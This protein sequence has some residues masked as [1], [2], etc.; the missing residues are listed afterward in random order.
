MC[1]IGAETQNL[2]LWNQIVQCQIPSMIG[3]LSTGVL[4]DFYYLISVVLS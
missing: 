1:E 3:L 4:D 2:I